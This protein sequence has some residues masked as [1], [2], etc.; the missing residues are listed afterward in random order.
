MTLFDLFNPRKIAMTPTFRRGAAEFFR[1]VHANVVKLSRLDTR[2][3][4]PAERL[5]LTQNKSNC[6]TMSA[7]SA[8]TVAARC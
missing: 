8:E 4:N 5:A 3:T 1:A 2:S 7:T 6:D